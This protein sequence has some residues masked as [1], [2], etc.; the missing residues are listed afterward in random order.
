MVKKGDI[1][2]TIDELTE[3]YIKEI[4]SAYNKNDET[5][6]IIKKISELKYKDTNTTIS[7]K[8]QIEFLEKLLNYINDKKLK[9]TYNLTE[10]FANENYLSLLSHA[11]KQLKEKK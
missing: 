6:K 8:D 7:N 3:G 1:L 10:E 9:S 2:A 11:I 5:K 4:I